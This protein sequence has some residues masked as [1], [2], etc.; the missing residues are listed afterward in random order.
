MVGSLPAKAQ[1]GLKP[2]EREVGLF[3]PCVCYPTEDLTITD[4]DQ[5]PKYDVVVLDHA[6]LNHN[7]LKL[8]LSHPANFIYRAGQFIQVMK[9]PQLIRTYS[10][11]SVPDNHEPL[12][13]HVRLLAG[14]KMSEYLCQLKVGDNLTIE[15]P[16][17]ECFYTAN[18]TMQNLIL[19][20]TGSGLSPLYGILQD[21]LLQQHQGNIYLL[22][23]VARKVDLYKDD[24]LKKLA[25]Q[26]PNFNY[27]PCLS[28]EQVAS[29]AHGFVLDVALKSLPTVKNSRVFLCGHPEMVKTARKK[30]FL[31]GVAMRDIYADPFG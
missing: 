28:E 2:S 30:L 22:H 16:F 19:M 23:G 1:A 24:K 14:G 5:A 25:N 4:C 29:Y 8:K 31:A 13:L 20:G 18:N 21:A 10:L 27:L 7:I 3:L 17:G 26:F 9:D 12:T 15:G 6:L 11:A